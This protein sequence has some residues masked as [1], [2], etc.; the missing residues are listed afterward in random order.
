M[1]LSGVF[2]I[3]AATRRSRSHGSSRME[4]HGD[5]HVRARREVDRVEPDAVDGRG[6]RDDVP[7]RQ[8]RGAPEALV[9]VAGRR[10]DDVDDRLMTRAR[11]GRA[12]RRTPRAARC[13][14]TPRR[15]CP[16]TPAG[17]GFIIFMT[18][19][20]HTTVSGST[21]DADVHVRRGARRLR[22]VER[23]EH[24]RGDRD[25]ARRQAARPAA[26][27]RSR[28]RP[29]PA[30]RARD[31]RS[32]PANA[33][34]ART[35]PSRRA[36]PRRRTRRSAG[37]SRGCRRRSAASRSGSLVGLCRRRRTCP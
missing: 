15:S 6:D 26:E 2:G 25:D 16:A 1:K 32:V 13:R 29:A 7:R 17:I 30:G 28:R 3:A 11:P 27:A 12:A 10:V 5:G 21:R 20:R 23:P 36:A 18:S 8:A 35:P 19:I 37:G 33:R 34:A 24:R 14:R 22:A 9:A 4:A 31:G